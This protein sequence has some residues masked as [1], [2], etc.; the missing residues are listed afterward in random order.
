MILRNTVCKKWRG[1]IEL[2]LTITLNR[3]KGK[4]SNFYFCLINLIHQVDTEGSPEEYAV[5]SMQM[6]GYENPTYKYF[7]TST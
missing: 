4:S 7:E 3:G 5:S 6:T 2:T 1:S